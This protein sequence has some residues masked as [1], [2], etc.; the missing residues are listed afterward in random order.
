MERTFEAG[1]S[2]MAR[3]LEAK[4]HLRS[5]S[6]QMLV[7][8]ALQR[9]YGRTSDD[10][11]EGVLADDMAAELLRLLRQNFQTTRDHVAYLMQTGLLERRAGHA[12]RVALPEPVAAEL[13]CALTKAAQELSRIAALFPGSDAAAEATSVS[14]PAPE[15][16]PADLAAT[17][18]LLVTRGGTRAGCP[19]WARAADRWPRTL[20]RPD[21]GGTG[22]LARALPACGRGW[23]CARDRSRFNQRHACGWQAHHP[24]HPAP[25]W[26]CYANRSLSPCV[27][28]CRGG[29][30]GPHGAHNAASRTRTRPDAPV[31]GV[32]PADNQPELPNIGA[33]MPRRTTGGR[34]AHCRVPIRASRS[35][36]GLP[37]AKPGRRMPRDERIRA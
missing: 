32:R 8:I 5:P 24:A 22:G 26:D 11:G 20:E 21:A 31:G 7:L 2:S 6:H 16:P 3:R 17:H 28:L 34:S 1:G 9:W 27:P 33:V 12:L 23:L 4:R 15:I 13:D 30:G 29:G 25:G 19:A 37:D 14:R 18:I 36:R 35:A 10:Q